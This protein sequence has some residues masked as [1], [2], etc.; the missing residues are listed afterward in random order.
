M[1]D[2]EN[3]TD[4]NAPR[5]PREKELLRVLEELYGGF[6]EAEEALSAIRRGEVDAFLV[7]TDEGEKV[8][9]LKTAEQPYRIL[10]EQMQEG[11]ALVSVDGT[12]LYCNR[13]LAQLLKTPLE[14]LMGESIHAFI[15]PTSAESLRRMLEANP[16]G[17]AGESTLQARDG[18]RVPVHLSLKLMPM[19][20]IQ[21]FSL[22]ATDLTE[23]KQAEETLQ[24]AHDELEERVQERTSELERAN[25][26]LQSEI[27][28]RKRVEEE[29]QSIARFPA[30]NPNPTLRLDNGRTIIYVNSAARATFA[31]AFAGPGTD[32]PEDIAAIAE[33][34][35]ASGVRQEV[36]HHIGA[37]I[38][39]LTFVPFTDRHYV[40]V[41]GRNIT[42]RKRAEEALQ[43]SET[44]E[45]RRASELQTVM[46][47]VPAGI[48]IAPDP[49]GRTMY[50]NHAAYDQMR[51]PPGSNLSRSAP[52][53]ER[54]LHFRVMKDGVEIPPEELPVQKAAAT[55]RP[56]DRAEFD[57]V[58][59]DGTVRQLLGN[60]VPLPDE[61]GGTRGAVGI[62]LDISDRKRMEE[63]L[64]QSEQS[65]AT[66]LDAARRL[67]QVSTQMI[68]ADRVEALYEEILDTAVTILDADFA[69]IQMLYPE[70]GTAGEL[71]LLGHRG[72]TEEAARFWEWVRPD[73]ESSCG[74]A[75]LTGQRVIIP[76]VLH[77]EFQ[78]GSADREVS[79]QTGIRAVQTTPLY[80]RS[81]TLL[82]MLSTHWRR[83]HE[84]TANELLSIDL[85]ARQAADL[86]DRKRA[87]EALRRSE[88]R[89][90]L[91]TENA[92]DIVVVLDA[93]GNIS[94]ASPSV[95]QVGGYAPEELIGRSA[96]EL[97][98]PDDLPAVVNALSTVAAR[99]EDRVTLEVRLRHS[100]G[101]WRNFDV[102]GIN[103]LKEPAV[104]GFVVNARD[105]T[106]R[107]RAEDA[108][109]ESEEK[110]R[111]LVE[112]SLDGTLIL[113]LEGTILFA[114][115]AAGRLAEIENPD[116]L[117]GRNVMEFI[118]PV[119]LDDA[120]RDFEQVAKGI[121][122]YVARYKVLTVTQE[123]RW[124]ESIGKTIL[125][126]GAPSIL[127]SLRDVTERQR[128]EEALVRRT[129]ELVRKSAE[130]EAA[131]DEAH[132]Y[133][134]IMTHDIRNVNNVS[135]MYADLL[136]ELAY[137]DLKAYA[138]KLQASIERSNEILRNVATVRRVHEEETGLVPINL[139]AVIQNEISRFPE[140]SIDYLDP[141]V[142]V[143][144]D[145]L[146]PTVFINLIGNA[147]KFGGPDV[148]ITVRAEVQDGEVLVS[149]E[150][151]GPGVPDEVKAKLFRRFE[152]GMG[153]GSG[154]GLGLF[155]VRT[156]V[157]RY[158][159]K[160]QVEDRVPGRPAE[161]AAFRFTL[162]LAA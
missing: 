1:Q 91:L 45:R 145:G 149:V 2:P 90:R 52:D 101:E 49:E 54:P 146:L 124:I 158:G 87:E 60:A 98:H 9:T 140:A 39:L 143:L 46:E 115:H 28:E 26:R 92:S 16:S 126:G 15:A 38:Y 106:D 100:S 144:A 113:D 122:A 125:F 22:V 110:F 31:E 83:P 51:M 123:A 89:F 142:E 55:G 136:T 42:E 84:P 159:G 13:S 95:R 43:E 138:E 117:I 157:E 93:G 132:M 72:F 104:R 65:L 114:N 102:I 78:A 18:S 112:H 70:R 154:E 153:R 97:T 80:S 96:L 141:Q 53:G 37:E 88:E 131:R 109:R 74:K 20:G 150:D 48:F 81:G 64:R 44:R 75:L 58:F 94:Y 155:I 62:F 147:V 128:A 99:P 4:T 82:G 7:S 36:E 40:N 69:S 27:V 63:A 59:D 8:Y 29:L 6:S 32:A 133:L 24:R 30:E 77:A 152:R 105:I 73:S 10:I 23:R 103:L 148:T 134:D 47:A 33:T 17:S 85:L 76:D 12:I 127:I 156:L 21:V 135:G 35:L 11:A 130:V 25:T 50:G 5:L 68:Q 121:D 67:Q 107:R 79:L 161:G 151:T 3:L 61:N 14:R 139:D 56:V 160:V 57:L 111:A 137:G 19:D 129:E 71:R 120:L 66:E 118:A 41:Y 119:S 86:I 116:E 108:L 162:K 34:A